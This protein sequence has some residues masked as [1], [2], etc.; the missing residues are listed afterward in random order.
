MKFQHEAERIYAQD[1]AGRLIAEVTFP[2]KDGVANITHTFV[3]DSLRGQGVAS[4]LLE[5]AVQ[6]IRE[7][8][9]K[10]KLTCSYAIKW[11]EDHTEHYDLLYWSCDTN[12]R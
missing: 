9:L 8:K 11:F 2:V 6:S 12:R 7:Q 4:K 10:A 3:D 1:E 5:A